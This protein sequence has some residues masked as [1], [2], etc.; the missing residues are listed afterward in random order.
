MW[1]LIAIA[2]FGGAMAAVSRYLRRREAE[3][4][5]DA[6]PS[7]AAQ[8]GVRHFFDFGARGWSRDGIR[9]RPRR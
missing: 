6:G 7:E 1:I 8:P 5:F 3:G 9:Q 4:D 2:G